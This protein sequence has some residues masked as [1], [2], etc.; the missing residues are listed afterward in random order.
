MGNY[1]ATQSG[2]YRFSAVH[3]KTAAGERSVIWYT[4]GEVRLR[5]RIGKRNKPR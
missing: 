5:I 4:W 2:V 3:G 1:A